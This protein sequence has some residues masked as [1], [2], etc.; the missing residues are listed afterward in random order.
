MREE[1][2]NI[3]SLARNN[4]SIERGSVH[5]V[6]RQPADRKEHQNENEGT[7]EFPFLMVVGMRPTATHPT[8][9]QLLVDPHEDAEVQ[10][11]HQ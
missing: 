1:N 3:E 2:A 5:E 10:H 6:Q 8:S 7:G 4:N 11:Q 9:S